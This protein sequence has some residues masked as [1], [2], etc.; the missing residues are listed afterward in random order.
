MIANVEM[1]KCQLQTEKRYSQIHAN[2]CTHRFSHKIHY[3]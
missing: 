1:R 2:H 3:D